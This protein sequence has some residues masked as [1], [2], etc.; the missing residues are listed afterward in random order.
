MDELCQAETGKAG[1][2]DDDK[3]EHETVLAFTERYDLD[4]RDTD[5][6]DCDFAHVGCLW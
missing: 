6:R 5:G 3:A 1:Q 2:G 4:H